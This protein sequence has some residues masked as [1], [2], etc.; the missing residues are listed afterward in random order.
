MGDHG[1]TQ[2]DFRKLLSTPRAE[3]LG[4]QTPRMGA[5]ASSSN[6]SG[7]EAKGAKPNKPKPKPKPKE[8]GD[9]ED[10]GPKYRH[11]HSHATSSNQLKMIIFS[12]VLT[13]GPS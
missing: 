5:A 9:E 6:A 1:L 4:G 3:R 10:E 8:D 13:Q 12:S 7:K 2:D 11:A